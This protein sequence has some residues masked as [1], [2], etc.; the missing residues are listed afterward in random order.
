[1]RWLLPLA[2]VVC[3][4]GGSEDV[5]ESGACA[6]ALGWHGDSY[7]GSGNEGRLKPGPEL[8]EKARFPACNDAGQRDEGTRGA[9]HRVEGVDPLFALMVGDDVYLNTATFPELRTH[10]LH[11][12][13]G[14]RRAAKLKG[15]TCHVSGVASVRTGG[16]LI[17]GVSIRLVPQTDVRLQRA[18]SG[19]IPEGTRIRVTAR[20][21]HDRFVTA[22]R[23][24]PA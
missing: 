24:D 1:M 22:T 18:G 4:C 21:C 2:L 15:R 19:Y 16:L 13:L 12:L 3:A 5:G 17:G 8:G 6:A 23:I 20:S 11:D 9:V 7:L 14:R 10:P